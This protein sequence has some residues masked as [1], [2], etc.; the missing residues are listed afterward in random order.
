[1]I[2]DVRSRCLPSTLLVLFLVFWIDEFASGLGGA[3]VGG[4]T[5]ESSDDFFGLQD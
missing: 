5:L 2:A 4:Y 1:M 3:L